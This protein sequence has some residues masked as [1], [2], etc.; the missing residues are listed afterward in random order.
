MITI[1]SGSHRADNKTLHFAKY[2]HRELQHKTDEPIRLLDLSEMDEVVLSKQMYT[3]QPE[4]IQQVQDEYFTPSEKFWFLVPEYNGS[5][6]GIVKLLLD[7]IS[8]RDKDK[9]FLDKKACITGIAS[10]RAGNLRGM[11]HLC[12]VL[13]HLGICVHPNKN[14][15]SSIYKLLDETYELVDEGTQMTLSKQMDQLLAF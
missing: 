10:G 5:Y 3:S 7:G 12:D 13:S 8:V 14:P 2:I 4:M 1:I 15:I 6:P 9:S 11:D